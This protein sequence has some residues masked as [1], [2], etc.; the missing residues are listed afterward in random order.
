VLGQCS[1]LFRIGLISPSFEILASVNQDSLAIKYIMC[2]LMSHS[3]FKT[4][5][6]DIVLQYSSFVQLNFQL[7]KLQV[8]FQV[9]L[10][11]DIQSLRRDLKRKLSLDIQTKE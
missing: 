11:S 5:F 10:S 2:D 6:R 8:E 3:G 7:N 1:F 4:N 9:K